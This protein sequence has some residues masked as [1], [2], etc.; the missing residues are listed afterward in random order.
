MA[1]YYSN[2]QMQG[3]LDR[4]DQNRRFVE[5]QLEFAKGVLKRIA[6]VDSESADLGAMSEMGMIGENA[7]TDA[8]GRVIEPA[9]MTREEMIEAA[10]NALAKLANGKAWK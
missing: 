10:K 3:M 2:Y 4:L 5:K 6:E 8:A 1:S 9:R 7:E